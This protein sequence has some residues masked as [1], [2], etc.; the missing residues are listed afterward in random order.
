MPMKYIETPRLLAALGPQPL[1]F[2]YK[3]IP[4]WEEPETLSVVGWE[5]LDPA[6]IEDLE[7]IF[8]KKIQQV[9]TDEREVLVALIKAHALDQPISELL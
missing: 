5:L 6:G 8:G 9:A 7:L 1:W 3:C 4:V 2:H